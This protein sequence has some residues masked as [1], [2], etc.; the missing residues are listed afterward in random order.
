MG[1]IV[2]DMPLA[3][4]ILDRFVQ[5]CYRS[6]FTGDNLVK[7]LPSRYFQKK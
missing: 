5:R 1:D 6:G 4:I 3:Y 2:I 7:N